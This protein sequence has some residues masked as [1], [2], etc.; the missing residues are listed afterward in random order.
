MA[1][2]FY[3]NEIF[4]NLTVSDYISAFDDG[5][6]MSSLKYLSTSLITLISYSKTPYFRDY[7]EL[8]YVYLPNCTYIGNSTFENCISLKEALLDRNTFIGWNAFSNC[9]NLEYVNFG[10]T[11][12][13]NTGAFQSCSKL[14]NIIISESVYIGYGA[15]SDCINLTNINA[16][17]CIGVDGYAF[18]GCEKL[19]YIHFPKTSLIG[20][21]AFANCYNLST[22]IFENL[23][24]L[25]F[26]NKYSSIIGFFKNCSELRN[27]SF[28]NLISINNFFKLSSVSQRWSNSS[29][30]IYC[31]RDI[32]EGCINLSMI[33]FPS[34]METFIYCTSLSYD[35]YLNVSGNISNLYVFAQKVHLPNLKSLNSQTFNINSSVLSNSIFVN[36]LSSFSS[37]ISE[38]FIN[39]LYLDNC[40]I[41]DSSGFYCNRALLNYDSNSYFSFLK[42]LSI[43]H[44]KYIASNIAPSRVTFNLNYFYAPE[45]SFIDQNAFSSTFGLHLG[46]ACYSWKLYSS[47]SYSWHDFEYIDCPKLLSVYKNTFKVSSTSNTNYWYSYTES[48]TY[49]VQH[50]QFRM[51][52]M[53]FHDCQD[54]NFYQRTDNMDSLYLDTL[55]NIIMDNVLDAESFYYSFNS[56]YSS[57]I[58]ILEANKF[59]LRGK[60]LFLSNVKNIIFNVFH[61]TYNNIFYS[62]LAYNSSYIYPGYFYKVYYPLMGFNYISAP[63]CSNFV[64]NF[65]WSNYGSGVTTSFGCVDICNLRSKMIYSMDSIGNTYYGNEPYYDMSNGLYLPEC[66]NF[67]AGLF[68]SH[69]NL[70]SS[71]WNNLYNSYYYSLIIPNVETGIIGL[72]HVKISELYIPKF[73]GS[74]SIL[75][76]YLLNSITTGPVLNIAGL[77]YTD[78]NY[79]SSA[80]LLNLDYLNIEN[81]V[82][83]NYLY[84]Q[85]YDSINSTAKT[86]SFNLPNCTIINYN[87]T[88]G[89]IQLSSYISSTKHVSPSITGYMLNS[90]NGPKI[91][92]MYAKAIY[93][94]T[95]ILLPEL[96][97]V[98]Y[99]NTAFIS[100]HVQLGVS[101]LDNI[102]FID[103]DYLDL[104][105]LQRLDKSIFAPWRVYS[106]GKTIYINYGSGNALN[107]NLPNV[108]YIGSRIFSRTGEA[109]GIHISSI[110]NLPKCSYIAAA[111]FYGTTR[112]YLSIL[113]LPNVEYI[114]DYAFWSPLPVTGVQPVLSV[115]VLPKC[116]YIGIK[117]FN[118]T[119]HRSDYTTGG[120]AL[121][122]LGYNGVVKPTFMPSAD[123]YYTKY[124]ELTI[125]VPASLKDSYLNDSDWAAL[126]SNSY[127]SGVFIIPN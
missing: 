5:E 116:S 19:E 4:K 101:T 34:T 47:L 105:N 84:I 120:I 74:I 57:Y 11:N 67:E 102:E 27:I 21:G 1:N 104:P 109:G 70:S 97:N 64:I 20:Q 2:A 62:G 54:F 3:S 72:D 93:A 25:S 7:S 36:Y 94:N 39:E 80:Y 90:F 52:Y 88:I 15:F 61:G 124:F 56:Q 76:C 48:L 8:E 123:R 127:Y 41:I 69:S 125:K 53:S 85:T 75:S 29:F 37:H 86:Y 91:K 111:A 60:T 31:D 10:K 6:A 115:V 68:T 30:Y 35:I 77:K 65:K 73:S 28:P 44:V 106:S 24:S 71:Y 96:N 117:A 59:L 55:E 51:V 108:E 118:V 82:Y 23:S 66:K 45:C 114:G 12:Y 38:C 83:F 18:Y 121:L 32:F 78:I 81:T 26:E 100:P 63:Q 16:N 122:E 42:I 9:Y 98:D 58:F 99:S 95:E 22:A 14:D 46:I 92:T 87:G 50:R 33:E 43:P 13:I 119:E 107:I 103:T 40:S 89:G 79:P 49:S 126:L 17:N 110:L 112:S 113:S